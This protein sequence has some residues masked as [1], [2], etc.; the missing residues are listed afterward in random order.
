M[1]S[2]IKSEKF[3]ILGQLVKSYRLAADLTQTELIEKLDYYPKPT[4]GFLTHVEKGRKRPKPKMLQAMAITLNLSHG[5]YLELMLAADYG[6]PTEESFDTTNIMMKTLLFIFDSLSNEQDLISDMATIIFMNQVKDLVI[7][8]GKYSQGRTALYEG[9]EKRSFQVLN[10]AEDINQRSFDATSGY[11]EDAKGEIYFRQG[12]ITEAKKYFSAALSHA[13]RIK[14]QYLTGLAE[15]HLGDIARIKG[16]LDEA[17]NYYTGAR[18]SFFALNDLDNL[19]LAQRNARTIYLFKGIIPDL[20]DKSNTLGK[21]ALLTTAKKHMHLKIKQLLSWQY[22]LEGKWDESFKLRSE[23]LEDAQERGSGTNKMF[24]HIFIADS[25]L[26]LQNH[27]EAES[28]YRKALHLYS[29]EKA[30]FDKGYLLLGLA[31][32]YQR[33]NKRFWETADKYFQESIQANLMVGFKVREGLSRYYWSQFLLE[34]IKSNPKNNNYS[35]AIREIQHAIEIFEMINSPYYLAKSQ[36]G[37]LNIYFA[38]KDFDKFKEQA[39]ICHEILE[40]SPQTFFKLKYILSMLEVNTAIERDNWNEVA[41]TISLAFENAL[42]FN[43]YILKDFSE[44]LQGIS[45]NLMSHSLYRPPE[46]VFT[47]LRDTISSIKKNTYYEQ[48]DQNRVEIVDWLTLYIDGQIAR[49]Q[50]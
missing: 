43:H 35:P 25:Y 36:V 29:P 11:L 41:T 47:S 34:K 13:H 10:Q 49:S 30:K 20:E 39:E 27:K 33:M 24:A 44:R 50:H 37:L 28:H 23:I 18:E 32:A 5:K 48:I 1:A 22:G 6:F 40:Q 31:R 14:D 46:I 9:E 8:W 4:K 3:E 26:Q 12:Q 19:S 38:Q 7:L 42:R 16:D 15:I 2:Q 21:A 17:L 45:I